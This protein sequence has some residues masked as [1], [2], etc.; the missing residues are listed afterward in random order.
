MKFFKNLFVVVIIVGI[1][2]RIAI[3][4]YSKFFR[5]EIAVIFTFFTVGIIVVP[6]ISYTIGFDIAVSEYLVILILWLIF[7][8]LRAK[9]IKKKE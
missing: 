7:D 6:I 4:F 2:T 8:L 3:F 9:S 1:L 5:K